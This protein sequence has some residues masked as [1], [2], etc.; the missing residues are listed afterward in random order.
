MNQDSQNESK[1][2][3]E[4]FLNITRLSSR[5]GQI[6]F[7]CFIIETETVNQSITVHRP[8]GLAEPIM[9]PELRVIWMI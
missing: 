1:I 7:C 6:Q 8:H 4:E 2:S 3:F 5:S 9:R